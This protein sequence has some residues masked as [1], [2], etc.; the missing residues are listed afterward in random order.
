[1]TAL[2]LRQFLYLVFVDVPLSIQDAL[3]PAFGYV[4]RALWWLFKWS[5]LMGIVALVCGIAALI[6][7]PMVSSVVALPVWAI[8]LIVWIASG[9]N[10]D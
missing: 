8:V 5:V 6:F 3:A 2:A 9:C 10:R 7:G 1:M 4:F